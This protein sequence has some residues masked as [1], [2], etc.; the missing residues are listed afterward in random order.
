MGT[1]I[2]GANCTSATLTEGVNC[3]TLS[4]GLNVGSPLTSGLGK[5]DP[6]WV[7]GSN[8]GLGNGLS[9]V[10]D[11]AKYTISD[12]T[13][14]DFK[15]Y[16]GRLDADV[17]ANDHLDFSMYWVPDAKTWY[18]GGYSYDLFHHDQTNNSFAVVWN[19]TFSPTFLN[20]ARANAAGWR[21]NELGSN[22]QAPFG[23]PQDNVNGFGNVSLGSFS[24]G[25]PNHLDQ[26]TYSYKDVATKVLRSHTIKFGADLTRLYYLN[27][28]LGTPSYSFFNLWD[29]MND[30]PS[31]E[32]GNFQAT[33]GK[34]GGFRN[35][36]RENILG[37][38][39]QDDWKV[40]PNLTVS[41]GLRY[42]YFGALTDKDDKM[43][44]LYFGKGADY[45]TG[46]SIV[47]G[48]G[49]WKA[50]KAN[51][52]PQLGFNWSPAYFKY[53]MVVRGGFGLN[54]NQFEIANSNN[55]DNNPPGTNWMWD[56]SQSP[57]T[58]NKQIQY[59][60]SSSP[61]NIFGYGANTNEITGFNAAGL[62]TA[63]GAS[64]S[65]LSNNL[66]TQ[67]VEHYS[68]EVSYDLGHSLV[69]NLGYEGSVGR[70]LPF[71][72]DA[73]AMGV[74]QGAALNPLVN[75]IMTFA[76]S[77]RSNNNMLLAG[78][79]HQFS[80]HFTAEG[81]FTWAHS[82][83]T[84]SGPYERD[85]YPNHIKYNYGRSDFDVNH[86]FKMFGTWQPV[87]FHGEHNW[88]E[89]VAGGWALSGIATFHSGFGWTPTFNQPHYFY[90]SQCDL[91]GAPGLLP[92]FIGSS[93]GKTSN[94]AFETGSNF[95]NPGTINTGTNQNMFQ[96]NYFNV[97]DFGYAITDNAGQTGTVMP[98]PGIGRNSFPGPS[99]RDVDLN[100]AKSF[101]LPKLPVLGENAKIEIKANAL[102][103]FN[104]T[105]LNPSSINTNIANPGLG[106]VTGAL[107]SRTVD[108]QARFNF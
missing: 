104:I 46:I 28:P 21:Y 49:G 33:T 44:T 65:A 89:K 98:T 43:G 71:V 27:A 59:G 69:A 79:K 48:R 42:S 3:V 87:I 36:N 67:Y 83:D 107:G 29:F 25:A 84:G 95:A 76:S 61:T 58:I 40:R 9:N 31:G 62:P 93:R 8:F 41:A 5:Q 99:Y 75:G 55:N 35:D 74:L 108:F 85:L 14:S 105:N 32:Y 102:N 92:R 1:Q 15:Q 106:K 56:M 54:Y 81:Q 57:T 52:G 7:N 72:Y 51:F 60:I 103:V 6:N 16:N 12:P 64:L 22:P 37:A 24:V 45:L 73:Q 91:W 38:F 19:H 100:M 47:P 88:K 17:T 13:N 39:I 96:D 82:M 11:I 23:L 20:E 101:G 4:G 50:Q 94:K 10:A 66:S 77:G 2:T 53:K 68:L 30:A 26:W 90:C 86:T 70:H 78:V 97:A 34:P 63:G 18:N 80:Q